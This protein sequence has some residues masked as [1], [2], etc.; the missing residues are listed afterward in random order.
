MTNPE[1]IANPHD[2]LRFSLRVGALPKI[3]HL[4][5]ITAYQ[6]AKKKADKP[7]RMPKDDPELKKEILNKCDTFA[8]LCRRMEKHPSF[9]M[10]MAN[11]FTRS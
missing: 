7:Y 10:D 1:A 3:T 4:P 11:K 5:S 9:V 2:R 8:N 6:M